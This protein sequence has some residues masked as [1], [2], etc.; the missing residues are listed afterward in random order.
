MNVG[1]SFEFQQPV[2][3]QPASHSGG[4]LWRPK[5]QPAEK[6][7]RKRPARG[8]DS[9]VIEWGSAGWACIHRVASLFLKPKCQLSDN[10][11]IAIGEWLWLASRQ[12]LPIDLRAIGAIEILDHHPVI[13]YKQA[14][15]FAAN[16][17]IQ[18]SVWVQID[19][20]KE[21]ADR[22]CATDSGTA[23]RWQGDHCARRNNH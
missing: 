14:G 13:Q 1:S 6:P 11:S 8:A 18:R 15:V 19:L 3:I 20:W 16:P 21:L 5:I 7:T 23:H 22:I 12:P 2:E 10:Q 9:I 4:D 17:I